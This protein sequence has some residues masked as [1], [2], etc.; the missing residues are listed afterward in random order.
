[1][2][3]AFESESQAAVM[4][5]NNFRVCP[6]CKE[7]KPF[8]DYYFHK[9]GGKIYTYCKI[10]SNELNYKYTNTE[11]GKQVKYNNSK[12]QA[13]RE[14]ENNYAKYIYGPIKASAKKRQ[15]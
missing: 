11:H 5:E 13:I 7:R 8:T 15:I 12:N 3:L 6:R 2:E 14:R 9:K 10:C 1:M 4:E